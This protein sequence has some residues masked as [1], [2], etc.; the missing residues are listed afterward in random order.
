MALLHTPHYILTILLTALTALAALDAPPKVLLTLPVLVGTA[1]AL[2]L[3]RPLPST[4]AHSTQCTRRR[5]PRRDNAAEDPHTAPDRLNR[6]V[7]AAGGR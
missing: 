1:I 3:L 7:H 6:Q 2:L 4:A 5:A